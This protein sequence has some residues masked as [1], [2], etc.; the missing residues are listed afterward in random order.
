SCP[1]GTPSLQGNLIVGKA[2]GIGTGS[3]GSTLIG[4]VAADNSTYV[5]AG[6][7]GSARYNLGSDSSGN[8]V[9]YTSNSKDFRIGSSFPPTEL[10]V[11]GS[12]NKVGV[13]TTSPSQQFS[14]AEQIFVGAQGKGLGLA[15]STFMGD[16]KI[17]GKLDVST[18]DPPYT[19]DGVK[20]AT[21]AP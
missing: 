7:A 10:V 11:S 6:A 2:I 15:T 20:Y 16:I 4:M 12:S 14:V 8:V 3:P 17:L 21:Y 18:I 9:E 5:T 1:S 13:G 19:I